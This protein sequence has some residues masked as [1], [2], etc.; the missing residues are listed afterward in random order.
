MI[1]DFAQVRDRRT[2][3]LEILSDIHL[4][5]AL[6]ISISSVEMVEGGEGSWGFDEGQQDASS[7]LVLTLRLRL[8]LVRY[9]PLLEPM[10]Q[11]E[12]FQPYLFC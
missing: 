11:K 3:E 1:R 5:L 10:L 4:Y 8:N 9:L 7:Y 6:R 12:E 2:L